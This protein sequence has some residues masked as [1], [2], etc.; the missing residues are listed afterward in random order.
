ML[1]CVHACA[2]VWMRV[3]VFL[4]IIIDLIRQRVNTCDD[5][6]YYAIDHCDV[7]QTGQYPV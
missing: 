1:A 4:S 3:S 6:F 7:I 5:S 2:R